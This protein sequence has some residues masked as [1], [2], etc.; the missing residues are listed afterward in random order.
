MCVCVY[1]TCPVTDLDRPLEPQEFEAPKIS[2]QLPYERGKVVSPT[3]RLPL[4]PG[5]ILVIISLRNRVELR[6]SVRPERLYQ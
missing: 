1:R 4:P 2:R 5:D 3:Q 6:A